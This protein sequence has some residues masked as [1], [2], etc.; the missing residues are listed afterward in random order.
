M[1]SWFLLDISHV[2]PYLSYWVLLNPHTQCREDQTE[3]RVVCRKLSGG[4]CCVNRQCARKERERRVLFY[5]FTLWWGG[6]FT[7]KQM[8]NL[9][10]WELFVPYFVL[11]DPSLSTWKVVCMCA[12]I[13]DLPPASPFIPVSIPLLPVMDKASLPASFGYCMPMQ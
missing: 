9:L 4:L 5:F 13:A 1:N 11:I 12:W 3:A 10:G 2:Q 6:K 7:S 8:P